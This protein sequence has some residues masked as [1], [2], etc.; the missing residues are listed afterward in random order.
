L[1]NLD[2][3]NL[4]KIKNIYKIKRIGTDVIIESFKVVY[5]NKTYIYYKENG[6]DRLLDVA[7]VGVLPN[8]QVLIDRK[9]HFLS[10]KNYPRV[11]FIERPTEAELNSA[12][13]IILEQN[14]IEIAIKQASEIT[15]YEKE[16]QILTS[17]L[18]K[19]K[20]SQ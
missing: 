15:K 3:G 10:L 9:D 20:K 8:L 7:L 17:K 18:E 13:E 14:R 11:F 5:I 2:N 19:L 6:S 4:S 16:I 1:W 12:K